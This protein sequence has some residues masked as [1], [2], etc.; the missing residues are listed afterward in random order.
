MSS[1]ITLVL[2]A[3][4]AAGGLVLLGE[5]VAREFRAW[6]PTIV[7]AGLALI[8]G[9]WTA[10]QL[11]TGV[12]SVHGLAYSFGLREAGDLTWPTAV[13]VTTLVGLAEL[14]TLAVW[15]ADQYTDRGPRR[16]L[17]G[18]LWAHVS[19]PSRILWH[20]GLALVLV[21]RD[22]LCRRALH[23]P[24][25]PR[26]RVE[27]GAV[28]GELARDVGRGL[29]VPVSRARRFQWRTLPRD[30]TTDIPGQSQT[31]VDEFPVSQG[32][33]PKVRR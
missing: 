31:H 9:L 2:L 6:I 17:H 15:A 32:S 24:V 21:L 22:R 30:T 18:W 23:W 1:T 19:G 4:A 20:G 3:A 13:R 16:R 5:W 8:A 10:V 25:R 7:I 11:L 28:L 26:R 12:F 29:V 33:A 27:L 14:V